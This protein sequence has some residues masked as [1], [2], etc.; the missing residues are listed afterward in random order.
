M[1]A[2]ASLI[3]TGLTHACTRLKEAA[4]IKDEELEYRQWIANAMADTDGPVENS[5]VCVGL[6]RGQ[7]APTKRKAPPSWLCQYR[8]DVYLWALQ[9]QSIREDLCLAEAEAGLRQIQEHRDK[10]QAQAQR[11]TQR[12]RITNIPAPWFST[13]SP[14]TPN[15]F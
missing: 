13:P 4:A 8:I 10:T 1:F 6:Q 12:Q 3:E 15:F 2:I 11:F 14:Q 7:M 5:G 9:V